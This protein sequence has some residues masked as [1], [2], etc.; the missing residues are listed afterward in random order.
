MKK[1]LVCQY[2]F[3]QGLVRH[4]QQGRSEEPSNAVV[5]AGTLH[6]GGQEILQWTT[7]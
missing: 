4:L 2:G 5:P 1:E 7:A 6:L 3:D